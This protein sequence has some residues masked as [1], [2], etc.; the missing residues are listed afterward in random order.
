VADGEAHGRLLQAL[1]DGRFPGSSRLAALVKRHGK[2]IEYDLACRG[3]DLAT[4]WRSRRWRRLL[5]IIDQLPRDSAFHE[6]LADDEQLAERMLE[7]PD[8][9]PGPP[10]R[11][12]RE[13]SAE[14]ELLSVV[15]DR[16]AEL[17]QVVGATKGSKARSIRHQPRPVTAMQKLRARKRRA[18][19]EALAA[20]VAPG[21]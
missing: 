21:D 8:P 4:E 10:T 3:I 15:V 14:V 5:N 18:K 6:S 7:R 12:M 2:A 1:R 20:R 11:R 19:H 16:L 9:P 17:I 13:W